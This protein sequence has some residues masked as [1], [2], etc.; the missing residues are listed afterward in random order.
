M[1]LIRKMASFALILVL[2]TASASANCAIIDRLDQ[3]HTLQMRLLQNPNSGLFSSD[4]R[5][6]RVLSKNFSGTAAAEAVDGNTF[7]GVGARMAAFVQNT[8]ALLRISSLDDPNSVRRHFTPAVRRNLTDV[9]DDLGSL[10]CDLTEIRADAA[11]ALPVIEGD[12]NSDEEDL[13]EVAETLTT[14]ADEVLQWRS[15]AILVATITALSV[16]IP[17]F[18]RWRLMRKRKAK[19]HNTSFDVKYKA[20]DDTA[21]VGTLLDI[22]C[23]GTK[24]QHNAPEPQETGSQVHISLDEAWVSGT[25]KW[26]NNFYSGVKFDK[27]ITLGQVVRVC[28]SDEKRQQSKLKR[29][30]A[31]QRT[32]SRNTG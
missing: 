17:A 9:G 20:K 19:R 4:I 5:Q 6:I 14:I 26:S 1:R 11:D 30:T 23:H 22:N 16:V 12:T 25:V 8:Q 15:L 29:K 3:L 21:M 24:L 2:W 27:Q 18:R 13:A 7:V 32:P 31:P 28:K 10:R